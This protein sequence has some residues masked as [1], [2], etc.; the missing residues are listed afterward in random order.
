[1]YI[2]NTYIFKLLLNVITPGIEPLVLLRKKF[3]Y[4]C[5]KEVYH[6]WAQ[7]RFDT[8][9][10]LIIVEAVCMQPILQVGK[11]VVVTWSEIRALRRVVKQLPVEMLPQCSS[12]SSCMRTSI[13][14]EENYTICQHPTLFVLNGPIKVFFA[15]FWMC[16]HP[17]LW[18]LFG[19]NIHRWNPCFITWYS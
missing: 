8:F 6:L 12:V 18:L 1:M 4:A 10:Q 11:Q 13:V 2:Q 7:P 16:V 5:V 17:L 3:L 9:H 14:M 15:C 19:F